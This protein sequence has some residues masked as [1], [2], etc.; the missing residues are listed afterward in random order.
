[1]IRGSE[2]FDN[3]WRRFAAKALS[4][5]Y[6]KGG[7]S[8]SRRSPLRRFCSM[9]GSGVL[10]LELGLGLGDFEAACSPSR[11]ATPSAINTQVQYPGERRGY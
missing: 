9:A 8:P 3:Q 2:K 5:A 7:L 4:L 1:M 11:P 6:Q 10:F